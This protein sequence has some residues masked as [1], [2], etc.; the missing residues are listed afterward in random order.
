MAIY[1]QIQTCFWEDAKVQDEMNYKHKYFYLY[2]LTNPKVKQCGC[3]ELSIKQAVYDTDLSKEEIMEIL[4]TFQNEFKIIEYS[5][6]TKEILI[7]KFPKHNWTSSPKVKACILKEINDVKTPE[8]KEKLLKTVEEMY[9]ENGDENTPDGY[10]IDTLSI[11]YAYG[12][13]KKKKEKEKIKRERE[14][15]KEREIP[16]VPQGGTA[17]PPPTLDDILGFASSLGMRDERYCQRFYNH[18]EA[19]GWVNGNGLKIKNWKLVF[20]NWMSKDQ[21]KNSTNERRKL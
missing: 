7:H 10:P 3:Y 11:P 4:K 2:L 20:R 12:R 6:E 1:R 18:Y 14:I 8:F 15:Y 16:Q 19:I 9:E 5:Y 13:G 17:A 21:I